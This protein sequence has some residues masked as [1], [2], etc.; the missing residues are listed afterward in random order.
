M[1]SSANGNPTEHERLIRSCAEYRKYCCME[2]ILLSVFMSSE[3][4]T[5]FIGQLGWCLDH[6]ES[7]GNITCTPH[8]C[9]QDKSGQQQN[10]PRHETDPTASYLFERVSVL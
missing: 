1:K 5:V 2:T 4:L 9:L 6:V 10:E 7:F 3:V 8:E